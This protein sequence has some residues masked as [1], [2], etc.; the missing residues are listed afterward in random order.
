MNVS[1]P[2]ES[3]VQQQRAN[4]SSVPSIFAAEYEGLQQV[5]RVINSLS[6]MPDLMEEYKLLG[7]R[8][9]ALL[10][11]ATKMA[12][13]G[14]VAQRRLM[15]AQKELEAQNALLDAQSKEI[16]QANA[17]LQHKNTQL[18][19]TLDKIEMI[20]EILESERKKAES[21]L[22][23]ILPEEIAYRL[24]SGEEVIADKFDNVTVL[25]ADIVGFT[26]LS[27]KVN[28]TTIVK[29][30]NTLFSKF[31][32][33]LETHQVE[34]IKTIGDCYMVAAG[35]PVANPRHA[36][37]IAA[38]AF[39][40]QQILQDYVRAN[41]YSISMRIGL[42]TGPIVAGII[43]TKKFVYDLWGDTVNTASRM[44]SSGLPGKI[45]C[46]E[47]V[48]ELLKHLYD[49]E[50]RGEIAVKGKGT[51]KTYFFIGKT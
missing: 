46:S 12:R 17:E 31:D 22:L 27:S 41:D 10:K 24:K 36:E 2:A 18:Q 20:N 7:Q 39:D 47:A 9:E 21:L 25:F 13:I 28:A 30:L 45:H 49:F 42:H 14:D 23:N 26:E 50:E 51:M 19:E 1:T 34:K 8:Y 48:Y 16:E 11:Q 33:L 35:I 4:A 29:I 3:T 40:M 43:G 15:N 32:A 5:K 38:M 44:E 6:E 37:L